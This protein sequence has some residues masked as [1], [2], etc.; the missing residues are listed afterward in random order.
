MKQIGQLGLA[1]LKSFEQC[2]LTAYLDG[3]GVPT[4]GWGHTRGVNAGDTC[5]QAQ[6]DQ[7]LVEDL[8]PAQGAVNHYVTAPINQNQFDALVC[9]AFN[10]GSGNFTS[11]T[12]L[13]YLNL[14]KYSLADSEF[15]KWNKVHGVIIAGLVRRRRAERELFMSQC[16]APGATA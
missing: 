13:K 9:L 16:I 11:S 8:V 15:L 10:I 6:A 12:L 1:L 5:T 3:G 4:I 14:Q 2:R 7:W